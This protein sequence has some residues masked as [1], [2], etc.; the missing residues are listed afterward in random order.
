VVSA[1]ETT[2]DHLL[3]KKGKKNSNSQQR[4][5]ICLWMDALNRSASNLNARVSI[6]S[7]RQCS[8]G[9]QARTKVEHD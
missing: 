9:L 8:R 6:V 2:G 7:I 5:S 4:S 1:A 3:L